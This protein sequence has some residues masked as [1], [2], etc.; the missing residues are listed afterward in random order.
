MVEVRRYSVRLNR[1]TGEQAN[2]TIVQLIVNGMEFLL[3]D[4]TYWL[5]QPEN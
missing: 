2:S 4:K 1:R 5:V 3:E